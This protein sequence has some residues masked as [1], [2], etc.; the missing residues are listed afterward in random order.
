MPFS[1][2]VYSAPSSPGAFNPAV[3]GQPATPTTWN[4]LL[5]DISTALS[6]AVL[7]D[8]TQT[9]TADI[10][11]AN[12][13]LRQVADATAATDAVNAGQI[14][15]GVLTGVDDTGAADAYV[16]APTFGIVAYA[17]YQT[18]SF[19][20]AHTNTT[21]STLAVSGLAAK[22]IKHLDGSDL[23]AADIL[24]G[25]LV[26]VMYDGTNFQL[27][28]PTGLRGTAN[29]WRAAQTFAA[30]A[31]MSAAAFN[32]AVRVDVASATTTDI[33]AAVSNYVQITGVVTITGLGTIASG[34][35]RQVV[36]SGI[37]VLTHNATSL[38]L[39]TGANITTAV[40]DCALFESEGSGNWRCVNYQRASGLP[41]TLQP[42][43]SADT[44][45]TADSAVTFTH[46]LGTARL[47]V[48]ILIVNTSADAS[49]SP[50]DVVLYSSPGDI[51]SAAQ[52]FGV[53]ALISSTTIILNV[54]T[55]GLGC[56]ENAST[57]QQ[58][59]LDPTK[60][61][62]RVVAFAY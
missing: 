42:Y 53:A 54:A 58:V 59:A 44:S 32:E 19:K 6:T 14:V 38:I 27:L 34:V 36:F 49:Y 17:A 10:P 62:L 21:T 60:W 35:R 47:I 61:K 52:S 2:G 55:N 50:G 56:I 20:A 4:A 13:K 33:G 22:T 30:T 40:G 7:K 48:Q 29:T 57:R 31:T 51:N 3:S 46:G 43:V 1:S 24:A 39:P 16:I 11:F 5:L 23:L 45:Y 12:H 18:F 28:S 15:A 26:Q 41:V 37:L 8:G 9:V 25:E